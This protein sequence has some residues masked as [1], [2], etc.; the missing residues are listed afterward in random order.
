MINGKFQNPPGSPKRSDSSKWSYWTYFKE[1]KKL[2][3]N[4]PKDHIIDE[5]FVLKFMSPVSI[6]ETSVGSFCDT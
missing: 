4:V 5:N 1:T 3:I 6:F 2:K